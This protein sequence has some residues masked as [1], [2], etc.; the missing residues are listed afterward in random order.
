VSAGH[1]GAARLIRPFVVSLLFLPA[2]ALAGP[3]VQL[4]A[5]AARALT[6]IDEGARASRSDAVLV[7]RGDSVLLERYSGPKAAPIELMSVTK[8]V[9]ALAIG[10]L[11][12]DG[13]LASLDTPVHTIYPEWKQGRKQQITIRML[14]DHSSGLQNN[15]STVDEIYPAPDAVQLAL[16]AELSADP[17]KKF[18]YNNKAAN[19]LAGIVAKLAGEPLDAYLQQRLFEPLGIQP[20]GWYKDAAGNPHGMAGL[21]L[22]A[23]DAAKLGRL[24]LDRGRHAGRELLPESFIETMLARSALNPEVGLLWM[25]R[26][27]WVRFHADDES[28]AMLGKAGI[29]PDLLQ[30]LRPLHGRRFA[31]E[32]ELHAALAT[33]WGEDWWGTW[34]TNLSQP[35]GIGPWKPFHP[36][37]GPVEAYEA[38]GYRGQYIVLIPKAD[39][40]AVR[41]IVS[42]DEHAESDDYADFV[43]RVQALAD[44][45]V[46]SP[47][48][49]AATPAP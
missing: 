9:V 16:A 1:P 14:M 25:R 11:L 36:E 19:L 31:N 43:A 30:K 42:R 46:P 48:A 22:T 15:T 41:Q 28:F 27:A 40:V 10:A 3:A 34:A 5:P 45:L 37:K 6:A 33:A 26:V 17:G 13:K 39:L 47:A 35:H 32:A 8:S 18:A 7:M 20:G 4:A 2:F 49:P 12:A 21:M 38:N 44:A 24:V 29:A 23:R